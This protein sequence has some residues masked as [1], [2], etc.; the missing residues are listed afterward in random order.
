MKRTY[1]HNSNIIYVDSQAQRHSAFVTCWWGVEGAS[2][3]GPVQGNP[4]ATAPQG[5]VG[6]TGEPGVNL[7]YC[8]KDTMKKDPYGRQ[9]ERATSVVHKSNQPAHGNYWCWPDEV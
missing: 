8:S 7:V 9:I 1:D 2:Y 3:D 4:P 5:Y 6:P